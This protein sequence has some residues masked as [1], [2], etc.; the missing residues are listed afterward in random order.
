MAGG[1]DVCRHL[2]IHVREGT[3]RTDVVDA[4]P[5][6]ERRDRRSTSTLAAGGVDDAA[7]ENGVSLNEEGGQVVTAIARLNE[8]T[9]ESLAANS[10][11]ATAERL[12]RLLSVRSAVSTAEEPPRGPKK[13]ASP[14]SGPPAWTASAATARTRNGG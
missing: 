7:R 13:R 3:G 4:G 14:F 9:V 5:L 8:D 10:A 11:G 2:P 6:I 1:I 12:A